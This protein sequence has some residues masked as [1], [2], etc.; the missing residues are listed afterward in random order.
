M[1]ILF[2]AQCYAPENVSASVLITELAVDLVKRGNQVSMVTSVPNYPYGRVFPG[3]KNKFYQSE[4]LDGVNVIRTWSYI[5]PER[6]FWPRLLHYGSYSAT[7]FY[8]GL[9]Y[10]KPDVIVSYSPPLPLGISAWLL[11]RIWGVPWVLQLEDLYPD[12]AVAAGVLRNRKVIAFFSAMERFLYSHATHIS[13]ISESFRRNLINKGVPEVKMALIPVWAD[14]DEVQPMSTYNSFRNALGLNDK[15]VL[16]YAGN[17][18]LTSS[19][20]DIVEAADKL[21]G[22]PKICFVLVGEGVKKQPLEKLAE[23]KGLSNILFLPYQAR[24]IFPE[25]LA[26]ADISFVTLNQDSSVSSLP[27]KV[28]NLMASAR[29]ILSVSP[30]ESELAS[31]IIKSGCGVNVPVGQPGLLADQICVLLEQPERLEDMGRR[32]RTLLENRFSR[33]Q[34]VDQYEI[35]LKHVCMGDEEKEGVYEPR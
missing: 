20:E 10:G 21:R 28:F 3:Y 24:E 7:A 19:L 4:R 17:M 31:L 16:L 13:I 27:S 6:T 32:G 12:A 5:S 25:V 2:L 26:A 33:K 14:P 8:G 22:Y 23:S 15:F 35:M 9:F 11:S 34:C 18:G 30:P 1:N 29:P